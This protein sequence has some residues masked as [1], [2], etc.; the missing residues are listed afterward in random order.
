MKNN[1]ELVLNDEIIKYYD[2]IL[3]NA[4]NDFANKKYD[5]A[6]NRLQEELDQPY[7]P[8]EY[9]QVFENQLFTFQSEYR[10]LQID[11]KLKSLDK[12]T[13]LKR[14]FVNNNFNI[15]LFDYFLQQFHKDIDSNDLEIFA[16]W[17]KDK[18]LDNNQKFYILDA[19]ANFDIDYNF[20]L[21]NHNVNDDVVL[22]TKTFHNHE[23]FSKYNETLDI[24]EEQL[25]K[26][27][28]IAKFACDL[29]N[30]VASEYF[31]SFNFQSSNELAN[32]I[33]SIIHDNMNGI[34]PQW[35]SLTE[36][37]RIVYNIL[38]NIQK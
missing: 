37:Q 32:I 26:D 9:Q 19:L 36:S 12:N 3:K 35:D 1:D 17:L 6:I 22:N 29:L 24:I 16:I 25:F 23:C 5:Q 27:P 38:L 34:E 33:I 4:K 18:V 31:P 14:V 20:V 30:A 10:F 11:E 28:V 2:N 21:H 7:M 13:M 8:F 15:Y